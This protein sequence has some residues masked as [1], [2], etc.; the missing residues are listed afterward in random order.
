MGRC[1]K[2]IVSVLACLLMV[3]AAAGKKKPKSNL[4]ISKEATL[5]ESTNPAEVMVLATGIGEGKK[6]QLT[7][8]A[9]SDAR[10]AAMYFIL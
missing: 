9:I 8:N 7:D 1:S 6:K 2:V 5:I 4:P 10:R 3:S